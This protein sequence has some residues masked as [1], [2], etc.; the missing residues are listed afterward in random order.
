M[1]ELSKLVI[2]NVITWFTTKRATL[3]SGPATAT[4]APAQQQHVMS[5]QRK[6]SRT[7]SHTLKVSATLATSFY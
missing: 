2:R 3:L 1:L 6:A 7:Y 4:K 5:Q